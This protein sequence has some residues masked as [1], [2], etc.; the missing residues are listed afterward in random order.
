MKYVRRSEHDGSKERLYGVWS[1]MI[2]R[3]H[4]PSHDAY[5]THGGRGITVC[6]TW[7]EYKAFRA[8]A[9]RN[10]GNRDRTAIVRVDLNGPY[11]PE[12]CRIVPESELAW[13]IRAFGEAKTPGEWANDRR[14]VVTSATTLRARVRR[15]W[16]HHDAVTTPVRGY[17]GGGPRPAR[18]TPRTSGAPTPRQGS[19]RAAVDVILRNPAPPTGREAARRLREC[20][21]RLRSEGANANAPPEHPNCRLTFVPETTFGQQPPPPNRLVAVRVRGTGAHVALQS[22]GEERRWMYY[23]PATAM[24]VCVR[25]DGGVLQLS[26]ADGRQLSENAE[27]RDA[28]MDARSG[29]T[30][31][32]Q[33]FNLPNGLELVSDFVNYSTERDH[34]G[35]PIGEQSWVRAVT[36]FENERSRAVLSDNL[37]LEPAVLSDRRFTDTGMACRTIE[38]RLTPEQAEAWRV[39]RARHPDPRTFRQE[40]EGSFTPDARNS[41]ASDMNVDHLRHSIAEVGREIGRAARAV[42]Q[43]VDNR[44]ADAAR[45]ASEI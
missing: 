25:E 32:F 37:A 6:E 38:Y 44:L 12:N 31:T 29:R 26:E 30:R 8:W 35:V 34:Q 28:M 14:C 45:R 3:C 42:G 36:F 40:Y 2:Q 9:K 27:I 23:D 19:R 10:G 11:S 16:N 22:E 18:T 39:Q 15:G 7:K 41:R 43:A 21:E 24:F 5:P 17:S 1:A 33:A 20:A 4:N 13:I